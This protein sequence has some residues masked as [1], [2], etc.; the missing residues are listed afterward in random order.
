MI[1][2]EFLLTAIIVV[3]LTMRHGFAAAFAWPG[4]KPAD[5]RR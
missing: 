2:A 5:T 1:S 3:L 4:L